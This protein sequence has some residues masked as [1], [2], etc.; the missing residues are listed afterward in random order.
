MNLER[1][2]PSDEPVRLLNAVLEELDYRKL[3]APLLRKLIDCIEV[4]ETKGIG[5]NRTQR[6]MI[7]YK[8]VGVIEIPDSCDNY[9][10]DTRKGVAVEYVTQSA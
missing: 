2:I 9:T 6:I 4:Y 10:A 8:F 7:H 3:T 1:I 5:Q